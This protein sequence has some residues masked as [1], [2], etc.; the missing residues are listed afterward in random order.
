MEVRV[1]IPRNQWSSNMVETIQPVRRSSQVSGKS[2]IE[3]MVEAK[4]EKV[5]QSN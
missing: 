4:L 1:T 2:G 3:K 5:H